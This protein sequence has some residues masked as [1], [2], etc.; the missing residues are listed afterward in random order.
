MTRSKKRRTKDL[1]Y[2]TA[3][4]EERSR[5]RVQH[6]ADNVRNLPI[7]ANTQ[8]P[9]TSCDERCTRAGSA[10]Y[11]AHRRRGEH[12]CEDALRNWAA[13]IQLYRKRGA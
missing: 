6:A 12:A 8:K 13:L 1:E 10:G 3:V 9:P 4:E 5:R 7:L 11:F 2:A